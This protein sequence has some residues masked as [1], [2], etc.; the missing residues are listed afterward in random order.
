MALLII[1]GV[2]S[3]STMA[4]DKPLNNVYID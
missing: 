1:C 3:F 2:L 4:V